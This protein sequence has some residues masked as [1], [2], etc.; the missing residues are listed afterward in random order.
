MDDSAAQVGEWYALVADDDD[1]WRTLVCATLRRAGFQV[2]E[3]R[4]GDEL[5]QRY[6]A[7]QALRCRYLVIVSDLN[8]PGTDGLTACETLRSS[9]SE[10]PIV[11]ITGNESPEV[12]EA[13]RVAGANFVLS[14]PIGGPALVDAVR[15]AIGEDAHA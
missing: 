12:L 9:S 5:L 7:L 3:A 10:I 8:M 15:Q 2:C 1:D 14:K 4:D 6:Q 11:I 13:A